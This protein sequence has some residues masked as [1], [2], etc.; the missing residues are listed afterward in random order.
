MTQTEVLR[1]MFLR[2][3]DSLDKRNGR[4]SLYQNYEYQCALYEKLF[5][6]PAAEEMERERGLVCGR[7]MIALSRSLIA[8]EISGDSIA[9]AKRELEIIRPLFLHGSKNSEKQKIKNIVKERI[10]ALSPRCSDEIVDA[11]LFLYLSLVPTAK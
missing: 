11:V 8:K 7:C 6:A 10:D 2:L 3:S 1:S 9:A 5:D 4:I